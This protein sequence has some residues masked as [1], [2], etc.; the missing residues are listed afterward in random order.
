VEIVRKKSGWDDPV[1]VN[2]ITAQVAVAC[3]TVVDDKRRLEDTSIENSQERE[4]QQRPEPISTR[5][6][7]EKTKRGEILN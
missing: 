1:L 5:N 2:S 6:R 4:K 3:N 7:Q